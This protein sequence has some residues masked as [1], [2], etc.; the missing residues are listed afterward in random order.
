MPNNKYN[1][2]LIS[3]ACCSFLA[4]LLHLS[5]IW[6]GP[7]LYSA[8]GAGEVIAH[9]AAAGDLYPTIVTLVITAILAVWGAYAL[10]G[11]GVL[12][13]LPFKWTIL[14]SITAFYLLRGIAFAPMQIWLPGRSMNLWFWS[15]SICFDIGLLHIAGLRQ[16]WSRHRCC[17][18]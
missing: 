18:P 15:S 10:S 17:E 8:I 14:C 3:A 5:C 4:A 9:M 11:A 16:I 7:D 6:F 2:T 12:P 1:C 13:S